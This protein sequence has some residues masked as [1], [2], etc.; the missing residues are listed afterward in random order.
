ML[1]VLVQLGESLVGTDHP[2]SMDPLLGEITNQWNP[3]RRTAP[4]KVNWTAPQKVN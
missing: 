1:L 3:D 4:Q 2:T